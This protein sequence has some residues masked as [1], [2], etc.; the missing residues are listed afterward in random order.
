MD[1]KEFIQY[2]EGTLPK[3]KADKYSQ[4]LNNNVLLKEA[5][6]GLRILKK[7]HLR[8]SSSE[9]EK[10]IDSIISKLN[11][12]ATHQNLKKN[13]QKIKPLRVVS[14]GEKK[15]G[16][17]YMYDTNV[18]NDKISKGHFGNKHSIYRTHPNEVPKKV[19]I[20]GLQSIKKIK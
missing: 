3:E 8:N 12:T 13:D 5:V 19:G 4:L 2:L 16:N 15:R 1:R 14:H 18:R 7:T 20:N 10:Y 6:E 11:S 9:L 17:N